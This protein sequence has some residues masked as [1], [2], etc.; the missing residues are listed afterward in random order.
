MLFT[1]IHKY[2]KTH[3]GQ[4]AANYAVLLP[5]QG[6]DIVLLMQPR[7]LADTQPHHNCTSTTIQSHQRDSYNNL[8]NFFVVTETVSH[9][10]HCYVSRLRELHRVIRKQLFADIRIPE[11]AAPG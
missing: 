2:S 5:L 8:A 7:L 3:S 10:A 11:A 9:T 4:I 6:G 1:T